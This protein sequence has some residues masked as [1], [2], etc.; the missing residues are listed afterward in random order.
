MYVPGKLYEIRLLQLEMY[1]NC[2]TKYY[3][4]TIAYIIYAVSRCDRK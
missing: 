4:V 2:N 1:K 3:A